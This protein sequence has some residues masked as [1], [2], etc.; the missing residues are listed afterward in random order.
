MDWPAFI[1]SVPGSVIGN[2]EYKT[3]TLKR[4]AHRA[5]TPGLEQTQASF[6]VWC[7]TQ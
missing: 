3:P 7:E 6:G 1:A 4:S 2:V 5:D